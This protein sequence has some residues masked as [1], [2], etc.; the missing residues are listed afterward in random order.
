MDREKIVGLLGMAQ[1]AG[2]IASGDVAIR[3]AMAA[4]KARALIL[5]GDA[6]ERLRETL[7]HEAEA[8]GL[9]VYTVLTKEE[10]GQCLG[11]EYRAAAALLDKGFAKTLEER[12][13]S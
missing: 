3:K 2:K 4:G 10:L 12:L 11:K 7:T 13:Q 5:A 9:P 1:R 6:S 8:A